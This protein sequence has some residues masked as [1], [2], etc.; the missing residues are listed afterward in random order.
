MGHMSFNAEIDSN[1]TFCLHEEEKKIKKIDILSIENL[2][3][4]IY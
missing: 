4:R 3:Y 2:K 1:Q